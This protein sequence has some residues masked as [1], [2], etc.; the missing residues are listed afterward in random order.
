[1]NKLT[2]PT[3]ASPSTPAS[4]PGKPYHHGK[5]H[6]SLLV[7]AR[8]IL[9]KE[10][11]ANLSLRAA[12]RDT[13]VSH[14]APRNHFGDMTGLLSELAARGW[15]ELGADL[16]AA[17]PQCQGSMQQRLARVSNV[18]V[19]Y[20]QRHS[21]MFRLMFRSE[22]LDWSRPALHKAYQATCEVWSKALGL[23][24]PS[25]E[26]T[27]PSASGGQPVSASMGAWALMHGMATLFLDGR[28]A[29]PVAP[30]GADSSWSDLSDDVVA[31]LPGWLTD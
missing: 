14:A 7:A 29:A 17:L 6:E 1:M 3:G 15:A 30:Q 12:A 9:E 18:Y 26:Q 11:L 23:P 31:T 22:R 13:G 25:A 20:A 5:L 24:S 2:E 4:L 27:G 8:N 16:T 19:A 28:L 21:A 10:G